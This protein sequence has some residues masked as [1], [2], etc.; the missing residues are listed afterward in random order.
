MKEIKRI[1]FVVLLF[2]GLSLF[3][4]SSLNEIVKNYNRQVPINYGELSLTSVQYNDE[5]FT[6]YYRY[7][8]LKEEWNEDAR[9]GAV[10]YQGKEISKSINELTEFQTI[11]RSGKTI[12]FLYYDK[13]GE[14]IYGIVFSIKDG[15]YEIDLARSLLMSRITV[16]KK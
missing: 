14:P 7:E 4:Q 5:F 16:P 10:M 11:R 12:V 8:S 15:R 2:T 13:R 3:S 6:Y 1:L 9:L